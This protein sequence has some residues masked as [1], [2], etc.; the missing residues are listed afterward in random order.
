[1]QAL[2]ALFGRWWENFR[3]LLREKE[4][5]GVSKGIYLTG[6]TGSTG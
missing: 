6:F 5:K 4:F 2:K 3:N 1:M